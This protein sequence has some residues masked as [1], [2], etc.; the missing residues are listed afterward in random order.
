VYPPDVKAPTDE[1]V[2]RIRQ[3][4]GLPDYSNFEAVGWANEC[5]EC[6]G[7]GKVK[8]GSKVSGAETT[9]CLNCNERGWLNTRGMTPP[10]GTLQHPEG[11]VLTGP[12]VFGT[13]PDER[14][15]A[16]ARDGYTVIPPMHFNN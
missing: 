6:H 1:Q 9:G 15:A 16:L 4:A 3:F 14:V 12:T 5:P 7:Y 13:E 8:T 2:S 11:E 10:N